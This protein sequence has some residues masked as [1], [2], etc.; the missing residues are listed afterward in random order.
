M[1][2]RSPF[3]ALF[4]G[5]KV[6]I[7]YDPDIPATLYPSIQKIIKESVTTPCPCGC[8]EI[9]VSLQNDKIDVKCY[10]CGTSFFELEVEIGEETVVH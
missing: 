10:D 6:K 7:V 1:V 5:Y 9:Y 8:K 3:C 2:Q 4:G